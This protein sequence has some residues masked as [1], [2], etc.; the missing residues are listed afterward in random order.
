MAALSVNLYSQVLAREESLTVVYP[1]TVRPGAYAEFVMEPGIRYQTLWL[2]HGGLQNDT[3]WL[4]FSQIEDYADEAKL[5]VVMPTIRDLHFNFEG[6]DGDY[7]KYL[8]EELPEK[9]G[10]MLPISMKREDNYVAALSYGGYFAYRTCIRY[11]GKYAAIGTFSSPVDSIADSQAVND[12]LNAEIAMGKMPHE[13]FRP[14][15]EIRG[16]EKDVPFM[17]EKCWRDGV[18][19]PVIFQCAGTEDKTFASNLSLLS[20]LRKT[21]YRHTWLEDPGNHDFRYWD[22]HVKRFI[23]WNPFIKKAPLHPTR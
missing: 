4:R 7:M 22:A 19:F 8:A 23:D 3:D 14:T 11:P 20:V 18:D 5:L 21:G 12:R 1:T 6:R 15:E 13:P 17:L 10:G 16:T 9:L 2:L